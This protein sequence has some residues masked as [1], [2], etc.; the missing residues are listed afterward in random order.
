MSDKTGNQA[1][2]RRTVHYNGRVQGVGFRYTACRV[3][4]QFDVTGYVKNLADGSVEVV[5]E[6]H[7]GEV[8]GFLKDLQREMGTH[9]RTA[10]S[11]EGSSTS[12]WSDFHVEYY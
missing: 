6:S 11:H 10:T 8:D 4:N 1:R 12:E 2:V 3:A 7:A 5:A 9:I